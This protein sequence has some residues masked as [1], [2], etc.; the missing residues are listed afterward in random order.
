MDI[1]VSAGSLR[2]VLILGPLDGGPP[3]DVP[4]SRPEDRPVAFSKDG[5]SLW[6]FRRGEIP[7]PVLRIDVLTGRR[8]TW[9]TLWPR[10]PTGVYSIIHFKITPTGHAYFYSYAGTLSQ[11]Y[12]V[13][14]L[15]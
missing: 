15:Q 13:R 11:L 10:D 1:V 12:L 7:A 4:G 3:R 5:Q 6:A 9:K 14:G 2:G 8:E